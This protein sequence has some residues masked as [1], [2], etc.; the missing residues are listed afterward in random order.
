MQSHFNNIKSQTNHLSIDLS[1]SNTTTNNSSWLNDEI[2]KEMHCNIFEIIIITIIIDIIIN[3]NLIK[4]KTKYKKIMK[5]PYLLWKHILHT[6]YL[7]K[8]KL[9]MNF[10]N[11]HKIK[12]RTFN[13]WIKQALLKHQNLFYNHINVSSKFI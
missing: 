11:T 12:Q 3:L 5:D 10:N 4:T 9:Y 6:L 1:K 13:S 8:K 7:K 2:E